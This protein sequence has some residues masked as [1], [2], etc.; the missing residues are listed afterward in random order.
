VKY[1]DRRLVGEAYGRLVFDG[2]VKGMTDCTVKGIAKF[3]ERYTEKSFQ[4][5]MKAIRVEVK[6]EVKSKVREKRRAAVSNA[7]LLVLMLRV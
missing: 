1:N 5:V 4:K 7:M 3:V 2:L 6:N